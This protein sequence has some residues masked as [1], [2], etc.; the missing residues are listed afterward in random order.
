MISYVWV[1]NLKQCLFLLYSTTEP[2]VTAVYSLTTQV[3]HADYLYSTCKFSYSWWHSGSQKMDSKSMFLLRRKVHLV[4]YSCE[5]LFVLKDRCMELKKKIKDSIS[6]LTLPALLKAIIFKSWSLSPFKSS[7]KSEPFSILCLWENR[8][9]FSKILNIWI[10]WVNMNKR[11]WYFIRLEFQPKV[12]GTSFRNYPLSSKYPFDSLPFQ[13]IHCWFLP[14]K[15]TLSFLTWSILYIE[16]II[17]ELL[18]RSHM[19]HMR[20]FP[21]YSPFTGRKFRFNILRY[22]NPFH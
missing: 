2:H 22:N 9:I 11:P 13:K 16:N 5:Q 18:V 14:F 4:Y 7:E 6:H 3:K 1:V 19:P 17:S 15:G 20:N 10:W 12:A 8:H 21:F